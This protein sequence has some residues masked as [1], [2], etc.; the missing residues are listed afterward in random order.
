[1]KLNENKIIL[2]SPILVI[3][4]IFAIPN[5]APNLVNKMLII[6]CFNFKSW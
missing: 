4:R 6:I 1:M 3:R 2:D 5:I